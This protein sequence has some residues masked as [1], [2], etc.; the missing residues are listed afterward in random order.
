MCIED[1]PV[2]SIERY[3]AEH[4][5]TGEE[6]ADTVYVPPHWH[7]A[8]PLPFFTP[9]QLHGEYH[10]V[11]EGRLEITLDG[12]ITILNAGDPSLYVPP[13]AVHSIRSF[14]GERMVAQERADPPGTY[15]LEWV[16]STSTVQSCYNT[17]DAA[18]GSHRFF[19][20]ALSTGEF[21]NS[22]AHLVRALYD[23]DGYLPLAFGI[24]PLEEVLMWMIATLARLFAPPKPK[25]L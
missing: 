11:I 4:V 14:P 18:P 1:E 5:A 22:K 9:A 7:K 23:G 25:T 8:T 24:K 21:N 10:V 16:P 17:D 20:D 15:K 19:N 13:K 2:T 3:Y 6:G 12:K